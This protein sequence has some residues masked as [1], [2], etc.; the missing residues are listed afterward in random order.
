MAF[1]IPVFAR[2]QV[3]FHD[4][5]DII[6]ALEI[7]DEEIIIVLDIILLREATKKLLLPESDE[8]CI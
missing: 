6:D 5:L 2:I 1:P 4:V 8:S 3:L 7:G